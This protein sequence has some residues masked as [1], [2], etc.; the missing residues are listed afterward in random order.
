[1]AKQKRYESVDVVDQR[2]GLTIRKFRDTKTGKIYNQRPIFDPTRPLQRS[3]LSLGIT[4]EMRRSQAKGWSKARENA[5][6]VYNTNI[7]V[8]PD[9]KEQI[10][11]VVSRAPKTEDQIKEEQ[12]I[13]VINTPQPY[14]DPRQDEDDRKEEELANML[15]INWKDPKVVEEQ[16]QIAD[17]GREEIKKESEKDGKSKVKDGKKPTAT[18]WSNVFT[19]DPATGE[20]VGVMTRAQRRKFEQAN[21]NNPD[22][23]TSFPG[24]KPGHPRKGVPTGDTW[25]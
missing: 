5:Q 21:S 8:G 3:R 7:G 13:N 18:G 12:L 25:S 19:I 23:K 24:W 9:L 4:E 22:I 15:K 17:K 2:S 16:L 6:P 20:P 1:M 11:G 14:I 10:K